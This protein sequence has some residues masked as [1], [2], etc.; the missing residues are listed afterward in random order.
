MLLYGDKRNTIGHMPI[1][2]VRTW[3]THMEFRVAW[4]GSQLTIFITIINNNLANGITNN[5][6]I[7]LRKNMGLNTRPDLYW[8]ENN[9]AV[10]QFS[11]GIDSP[12]IGGPLYY[13][14]NGQNCFDITN[15]KHHANTAW[16]DDNCNTTYQSICELACDLNYAMPSK[17]FVWGQKFMLSKSFVV[18][19]EVNVE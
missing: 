8:F 10:L 16:Q 19:S 18:G 9:T 1:K 3:E 15:A 17:P 7:G 2:A 13:N 11:F 6:W 5:V 4:R 12:S 14:N